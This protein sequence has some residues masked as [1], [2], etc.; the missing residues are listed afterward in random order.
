MRK[1]W[2]VIA[3]AMVVFGCGVSAWAEDAPAEGAAGGQKEEP[4]RYY[5]TQGKQ[6]GYIDEKGQV[7][8]K[9]QY[10]WGDRF[11]ENRAVIKEKTGFYG[12]IDSDG[13][14]ITGVDFEA[15]W[16]FSQGLAAVK[17]IGKYGYIDIDGNMVIQPRF[18]YGGKFAE[19]RA[20]VKIGPFWG[21]IDKTGNLVVPAEYD[22]A[23]DFENGLGRVR[24]EKNKIGYV[25]ADGQVVWEPTQ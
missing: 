20:R 4:K 18:D 17:V 5:I 10:E 15:A 3:L 2:V 14:P 6:Y 19:E 9:P 12:Y 1:T 23:W 16:E 7:A 13:K 24:K 11:A 25:N 8:I 22:E 21:F